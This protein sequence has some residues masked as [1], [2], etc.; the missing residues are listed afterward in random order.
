MSC[1][2]CGAE[3]QRGRFCVRCGRRLPFVVLATT[4]VRLPPRRIPTP[5]PPVEGGLAP[6]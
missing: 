6:A 5:R 2:Q 3:Q 4:T 1:G